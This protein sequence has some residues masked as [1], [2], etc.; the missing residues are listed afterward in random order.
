MS[1]VESSYNTTTMDNKYFTSA[2]ALQIRLETNH[3]IENIELFL[4]GAKIVISQDEQGRIESKQ[5]SMGIAKANAR[6]VQ[7][8][9]NHVQLILN[10][11]V[12]QGNF[13]IDGQGHSKQYEDYIFWSRID[14][15]RAMVHNCYNWEM[16]EDDIDIIIDSILSAIEPFM[17]RLIGNKERESYGETMKHLEHNTL[18]EGNK[19]F[20][21]N[22]KM[23]GNK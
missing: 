8:I 20:I 10:P 15:A 18:K 5:I 21:D 2:S 22:F 3:L 6:G 12:V 17:T 23:W 11:Q 7:S 14:L 4:R 1:E 19:G 16:D 9:L 13:Y